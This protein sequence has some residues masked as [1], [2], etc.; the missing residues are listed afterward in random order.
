MHNFYWNRFWNCGEIKYIC[1][2]HF[3]YC[4]SYIWFEV[5]IQSSPFSSGNKAMCWKVWTTRWIYEYSSDN[6][7]QLQLC[8]TYL[9]SKI[10]GFVARFA[11]IDR[12]KRLKK[13][14]NLQNPNF[15]IVWWS[16]WIFITDYNKPFIRI[17]FLINDLILLFL[18]SFFPIISLNVFP[19]INII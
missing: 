5:G 3:P 14:T 12:A 11:L 17:N 18:F 10:I 16:Y 8:N 2:L 13:S 7:V 15:W 19:K 6:L 9:C 1:I 4:F